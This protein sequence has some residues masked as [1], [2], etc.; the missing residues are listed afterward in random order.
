MADVPISIRRPQWPMLLASLV[1][2]VCLFA[3]AYAAASA[4]TGRDALGLPDTIEQID[5]VPAAVRVPSQ[6]SVFVDLLPGYEGVLVVDGLELP[7]VNIEDLQDVANKPGQQITLPP[8]TIY[9]PGNATLTFDPVEG[10]EIESFG[11]G[12]H[13]VKVIY[14]KTIEGRNS[15]RSFTWTFNV[16]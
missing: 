9:E 10:A 2:A 12:E 14:W 4:V 13:I 6:T 16:F 8:T 1:I 3:M 7:T 11:Q 5:P 15:A